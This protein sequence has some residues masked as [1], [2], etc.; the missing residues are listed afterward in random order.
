MR[1]AE[2]ISGDGGVGTHY[3][4]EARLLGMP[5]LVWD[6]RVTVHEPPFRQTLVGTGRLNYICHYEFTGNTW[7]DLRAEVSARP[8]FSLL[9]G[10]LRPV[11]NRVLRDN[12][13]RLNRVLTG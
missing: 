2:R 5:P 11:L 1:R 3:Q 7:L 13:D 6:L 8:P 4:Q 9:G 12:L 10:L